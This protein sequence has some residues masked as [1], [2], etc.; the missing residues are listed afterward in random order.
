MRRASWIAGLAAAS[1]LG[2]LGSAASTGLAQQAAAPGDRPQAAAR[3]LY[4]QTCA[5]CHGTDVAGGL[6]PSLFDARRMAGRT[7]QQLH[8]VI[9]GGVADAGMPAFR[10]ALSDA[11]IR[12][13]VAYLR[14]QGANGAGNPALA[15][16]PADPVV[17]SEKQDFRI[18]VVAAGLDT[19]WGLAFLPDG[20]LLVTERPGR[21]RIVENGKLRPEPV[22]GTPVPWVRQD[23]GMLDVILHPDYPRNGWIYLAYT[24]AAPGWTPPPAPA[25]ETRARPPSPPSMTVVVRGRLNARN[26][27]VDQQEIF[28]APYALYASDNTHYGLRFLFG[29]DGRLFYSLG[30]RGDMANAQDLSNPLGKVHRVNDDGSAPK[31]NPFVDTPGAVPTIWSYGHRNPQGLAFDPVTGLLWESEHGPTGGD[32]INVVE[33]GRNYGWGVITMGVQP[34]LTKRSEPGMEQP[35][36]HYTPTIAPSGI[37]F[38]AGDRYPGWKNSLFVAGLAGQQ[39]RRLEIEGRAVVHQEVVLR[40]YGR[41][42][43]V[44]TGPDGLLYVLLQEKGDPAAPPRGQVIRL[45]PLPKTALA[46]R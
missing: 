14:S 4:A 41:T 9:A 46:D 3:E 23:A 1:A 32:E 15:A 21:L 2:A 10:G 26:A 24:D 42:R 8:D 37:A 28:R 39:L 34:G 18:E 36:V 38:Y 35:I 25:G 40:G 17:R 16:T 12:D 20:R 13:V 27:W 43:A 19:P 33:K 45:V 6:A 5:G 29:R 11:Q 22:A 30:D 7:D 44:T 31:D